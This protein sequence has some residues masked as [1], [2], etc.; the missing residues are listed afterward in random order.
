MG[1][2]CL[3]IQSPFTA[4][5]ILPHSDGHCV[6]E[7]ILSISTFLRSKGFSTD[8][9]C[10]D[11]LYFDL[12]GF[13]FNRDRYAMRA[14]AI[15]ERIRRASPKVVG[16]SALTPQYPAALEI[17]CC[18]KEVDPGILV[19]L[20][21]P[22]VTYTDRDV[23]LDS[24][25]VDVV[26]RGEGEWTML[27]LMTH[28][29]GSGGLGDVLG[30][31]YRENGAV[32]RN[33]DRP[34]GDLAELPTVDYSQVNPEYLAKC[35]FNLTFTRGCYFSCSYCVEGKFWGNR[36]RH[37]RLESVVEEIWFA[38]KN[39][40]NREMLFLGS[41]FN[42]PEKFFAELCAKM[43][44]MD[45]SATKISV[46][47]GAANLPEEHIRLMKEAG[48]KELMIAVES[49]HP[50]ILRRMNK[51][52]SFDLVA[53]KCRLIR[54]HGLN[55]DTFWIMGHPGETE[56][57]ARY[58]LDA[59]AYLWEHDLNDKQEIA[60]FMPYPG[61]PI[62]QCPE[63]EGFRVL[64]KDY[65]KYSR[66]DE[67]V[68]ELEGLPYEKLRKLHKEARDMAQYWHSFRKNVFD[69]EMEAAIKKMSGK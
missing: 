21:G 11:E 39:Y 33:P 2:D 32:A 20:G 56:E 36:V 23:L 29:K 35:N 47:V 61:L 59:M 52:I 60:I 67:P 24:P 66:F 64:E 41:V 27:E 15:K 22:H 48:I 12:P 62:T 10:V 54:K 46:L 4:Q 50:E 3:F 26:V 14:D 1:I 45:L 58:S 49:A 63:K 19:V 37:R 28:V 38:A 8:I 7:G 17:A 42:A 6:G 9:F 18:A 16:I 13:E 44:E 69:G 34:L 40:P 55:I 31:T 57:T 51:K 53:E 5:G 43:K 65:A 68:V 25:D 30:I